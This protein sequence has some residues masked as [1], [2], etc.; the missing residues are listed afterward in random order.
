M[1]PS[2]LILAACALMT[3]SCLGSTES[4]QPGGVGH[5]P[6]PLVPAEG[7]KERPKAEAFVGLTVEKASA[8]AKEHGIRTRV[9]SV[10]GEEYM[11]TQ[12]YLPER[13]NFTVVKGVVTKATWG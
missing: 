6:I 10:D 11:V 8:L 5:G 12:D 2:I 3:S 9:V 13:L 7:E 1:K 4:A